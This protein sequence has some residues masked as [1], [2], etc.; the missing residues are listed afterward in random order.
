M[1]TL[2]DF[3]AEQNI[4]QSAFAEMVGRTQATISRI[5][6]GDAQPSFELAVSIERVTGGKVPVWSWRAFSAMRPT[7]L[8]SEPVRAAE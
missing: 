1:Q 4:R 5:V 2:G 6:G 8:S 7:D 3:L